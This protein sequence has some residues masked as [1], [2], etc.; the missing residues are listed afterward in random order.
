[1]SLTNY[2]ETL[3]LDAILTNGNRWIGLFTVT[4][5]EGGGG[6][7][8]S[9]GGYARANVAA[10]A[11]AV[12]GAPSTKQP[13]AAVTFPAATADWAAG[14]T[15]VVAFGVFDAVSG[16]NMI[17]YGP[18]TTPRNVLNGDT[19]SFAPSSLTLTMD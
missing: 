18:L 8:V 14:A 16:G 2:G 11:A 7:E 17:W 12:A 19:P 15:Q 9:G 3:A 6:T 13:N 1:M 5:G 10:W 4:A